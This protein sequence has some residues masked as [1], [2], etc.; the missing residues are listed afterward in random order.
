MYIS[1]PG[2]YNGDVS[3][4][5]EYEKMAQ[6]IRALGIEAVNPM[7]IYEL[8]PQQLKSLRIE[9]VEVYYT[10]QRIKALLN[11]DAMV[12]L[13]SWEKN[14]SFLLDCV[15]ASSLEIQI[16]DHNFEI[17]EVM[18]GN[19][20]PDELE[21][22]ETICQEADRLV[23]NDRQNQYGHPFDD[24]TKTGK[25]WAPILGLDIVTPLQVGMCLIAVKLS[26]LCNMYKRDT[27]VDI[28]GYA[29]TL[30]LIKERQ[31]QNEK[32]KG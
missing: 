20:L 26:R 10:M 14:D 18:V 6:R 24:F 17:A 19:K 23:S 11:C 5:G 1:G 22:V 28:A 25:M 9:H 15:I 2:R 8:T 21:T 7:D 31:D 3:Y 12:L 29:K 27:V 4:A 32:K 13:E 16:L 30:S